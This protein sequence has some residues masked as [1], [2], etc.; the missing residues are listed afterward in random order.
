[1]GKVRKRKGS[2]TR[3]IQYHV[4]GDYCGSE[5]RRTECEDERNI[6]RE[7][8]EDNQDVA[9]DS[10]WNADELRAVASGADVCADGIARALWKWRTRATTLRR[11][12]TRCGRA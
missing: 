11:I 2:K 3:H 7:K 8:G 4:R 9:Y 5:K 1:M 12:E 6:E 10:S